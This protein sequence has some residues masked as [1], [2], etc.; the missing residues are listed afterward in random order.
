TSNVCEGSVAQFNDMSTIPSN[1]TNDGILAWTWDFGNSSSTSNNQN[2]S[3]QYTLVGVD[4]VELKVVSNFGCVDSVTKPIV[5]NPNPVVNFT[6]SDT[7][8]CE[9]FCILFND[10][11]TILT[12]SNVTW[13]WVL[14]DNTSSTDTSFTHCYYNDLEF[15]PVHYS[16]T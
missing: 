1:I 12:G 10:A 6:V 7:A 5:I 11:S 4:T 9:P 16:I 3:Q 14:G 13:K 8:G 2:A 15:D